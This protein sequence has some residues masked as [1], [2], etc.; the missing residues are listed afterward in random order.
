MPNFSLFQYHF[1]QTIAQQIERAQLEGKVASASVVKLKVGSASASISREAR[2]NQRRLL[3]A[4]GTATDSDLLKF[5]IL[6]VRKRG[7]R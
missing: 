2:S 7:P 4:F 3:T 6:K 1:G 5:N